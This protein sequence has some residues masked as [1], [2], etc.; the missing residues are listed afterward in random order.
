[1]TS[2]ALRPAAFSRIA[3]S[4]RRSMVVVRAADAKVAKPAGAEVAKAV[5]TNL[6]RSDLIDKVAAKTGMTKKDVGEAVMEIFGT[7][8]DAMIEGHSF[9]MT[10]F[11]AFRPKHRAERSGVNPQTRNKITILARVVP[12]FTASK[13]LKNHVAGVLKK[14][15]KPAKAE[16]SVKVEQAVV[17]AKAPAAL[18]VKGITIKAL[19]MRK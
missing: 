15:P 17:A 11:G 4:S 5:K 12:T 9:T 6:S 14:V 19:P 7:I 16:K 10:G 3:M 2:M 8:E 1:M 18:A 13:V